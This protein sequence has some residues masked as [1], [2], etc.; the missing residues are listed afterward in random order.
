MFVVHDNKLSPLNFR[1]L[2]SIV[3]KGMPDNIV[4]SMVLHLVGVHLVMVSLSR[5]R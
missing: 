1:S 5:H 4:D 2:E 3:S